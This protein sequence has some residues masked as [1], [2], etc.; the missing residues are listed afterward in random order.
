LGVIM[1]LAGSIAPI[2]WE[3]VLLPAGASGF[4][5]LIAA[6]CAGVGASIG[7]I[8][9]YLVGVFLGRAIIM[10]Y[11]KYFLISTDTL[12]HAEQWIVRWGAPT[13]LILRSVQYLPYKTY[14][15]AAGIS[16]MKF[17]LYLV[18]TLIGTVFRCFYMIYFGSITQFNTN[19]LIFLML[20]FFLASILLPLTRKNYV[21]TV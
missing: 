9:G 20:I 3:L 6:L 12:H 4:D 13:T 21:K 18:L 16:Q 11:G 8:I 15:L 19:N 10:K 17:S 5:P 14:N 2:P 7:S 1:F